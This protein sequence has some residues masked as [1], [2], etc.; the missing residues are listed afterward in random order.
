MPM[1]PRLLAVVT[2]RPDLGRLDHLLEIPH[3][4][5]ETPPNF[6]EHNAATPRHCVKRFRCRTKKARRLS[7][8]QESDTVVTTE[9][10][11]HGGISLPTRPS[12]YSAFVGVTHPANTMTH[13]GYYMVHTRKPIFSS[14]FRI[15]VFAIHGS[16]SAPEAPTDAIV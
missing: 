9:P 6:H 4:K 1:L 13:L 5:S 8:I 15:F 7:H 10:I 2:P 3:V 12:R 14:V 11:R 16:P